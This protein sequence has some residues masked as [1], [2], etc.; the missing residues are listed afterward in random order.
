[1]GWFWLLIGGVEFIFKLTMC[2]LDENFSGAYGK[3]RNLVE[4]R[5]ID[6]PTSGMLSERS[7]IWATPTR[8]SNLFSAVLHC[9]LRNGRDVRDSGG[10]GGVESG[11][12]N[13]FSN[14]CEYC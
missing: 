6:P 12:M 4:V 9:S 8:I 13:L 7:T 2:S 1:M 3:T 5:G 14:Y 10:G 11:T